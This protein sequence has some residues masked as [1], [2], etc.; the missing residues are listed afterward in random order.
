MWTY[1][2][3][4][5]Q[6]GSQKN[7]TTQFLGFHSN[8]FLFLLFYRATPAAY[9]SPRLGVELELQLLAYTIAIATPGPSCIC[10]LCYSLQQRQ[11][12]NPLREA[13]DQ[14]CILTDTVVGP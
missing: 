14:T 5:R 9:G 10:N 7:K 1:C 11:I 13:R 12:L 8:F 4:V 6:T 3:R 2:L